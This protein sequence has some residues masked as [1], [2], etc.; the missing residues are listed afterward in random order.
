MIFI[1]G[2]GRPRRECT[3]ESLL[4]SSFL[5]ES[6]HDK[7]LA[8]SP[9][10][11]PPIAKYTKENLQKIFKMIFDARNPPSDGVYEKPLKARSSDVYC[12]KSHMEYYNSCQQCKDHFATTRAKGPNRILF[13]AFFF[14]DY[15]NFR[16]QQ[17]K[18]K[19]EAEST[20]FITWKEFKTF[21]YQS[22]RDFR[23][24]VDSY[25]AK[26]KRDSQYQQKDVLNWAVYLEHLQIVLREFDFVVAPIKDTMIWYF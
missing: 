24:F 4:G 21:F 10:V 20:I 19:H 6:S 13:A 11:E 8:N 9:A 5:P 23:T 22:L 3:S 12:G 26:I 7:T 16:W 17:Y 25:W 15:I 2:R 14:Y 1:Q 18:R